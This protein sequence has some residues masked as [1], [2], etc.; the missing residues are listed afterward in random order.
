M[1][2]FISQLLRTMSDSEESLCFGSE[3]DLMGYKSF[4]EETGPTLTGELEDVGEELI[5]IHKRLD[6]DDAAK[7]SPLLEDAVPDRV[8][9]LQQD[10]QSLRW[11]LKQLRSRCE[12]SIVVLGGYSRVYIML[13]MT[14]LKAVDEMQARVDRHE[15]FISNLRE[16]LLHL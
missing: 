2:N 5:I 1:T 7:I 4:L 15:R 8:R 14:I 16:M 11:E 9:E 10:L 12:V 13:T 3:W 6:T